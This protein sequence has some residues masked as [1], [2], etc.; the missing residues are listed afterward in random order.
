M[1]QTSLVS[2]IIAKSSMASL[3]VLELLST[4]LNQ[5]PHPLGAHLVV[6][7]DTFQGGL[8]K[9]QM[10][11]EVSK[12]ELTRKNVF[13]HTPIASPTSSSSSP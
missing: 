1:Q 13:S 7:L 5:L 2:Y 4:L 10:N 3:V 9:I 6:F 12:M 11:S 8:Q